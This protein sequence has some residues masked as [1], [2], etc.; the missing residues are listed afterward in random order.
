MALTQNLTVFGRPDFP[1]AVV[2]TSTGSHFFAPVTL[3]YQIVNQKLAD[4]RE[5]SRRA[6]ADLASECA[7]R[8]IG[9]EGK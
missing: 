6:A 9:V 2:A 3:P 1:G 8:S 4:S 5:R 7:P